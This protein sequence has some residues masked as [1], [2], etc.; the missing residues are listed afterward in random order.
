MAEHYSEALNESM[1]IGS[2]IIDAIG[3]FR[4][5]RLY[6]AWVKDF[7]VVYFT[8][9][10]APLR[11]VDWDAPCKRTHLYGM[12]LTDRDGICFYV[13]WIRDQ[14]FVLKFRNPKRRDW[15]RRWEEEW[16]LYQRQSKLSR[17]ST[18]QAIR[19]R[20]QLGACAL[21]MM[22]SKAR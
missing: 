3:Y 7:C 9:F 16:K 17:R 20:G 2:E 21:N 18:G 13:V 8:P 5:R 14:Q 4:R 10:C 6:Q 11:S 12:R 22:E 1:R 15:L 19:A